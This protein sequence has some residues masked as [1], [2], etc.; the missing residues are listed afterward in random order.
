MYVH[1]TADIGIVRKVCLHNARVG[2]NPALGEVAKSKLIEKQRVFE[3][4]IV[5]NPPPLS[6]LALA[7]A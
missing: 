5:K 6:S 4:S 3:P 2:E 1:E 7:E